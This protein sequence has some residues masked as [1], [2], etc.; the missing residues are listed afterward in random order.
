MGALRV[1]V[2]RSR[3]ERCSLDSHNRIKN[4]T[5]KLVATGNPLNTLGTWAYCNHSPV[6]VCYVGEPQ[7][8]EREMSRVCSGAWRLFAINY[9]QS[10]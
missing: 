1:A 4:D 9:V 6:C 2:W 8:L 5:S 7:H 10:Q 3:E